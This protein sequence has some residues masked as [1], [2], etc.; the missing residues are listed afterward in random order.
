MGEVP[1]PML[2]VDHTRQADS[3]LIS[4]VGEMDVGN[5]DEARK[6][7]LS[8][9]NSSDVDVIVDMSE[10]EFIDSVGVSMLLEVQRISRADSN[11]LCFRGAHAEVEHILQL[12]RV[13]QQL[14][15][16]D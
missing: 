11:R 3:H 8:A 14:N 9:L 5:V 1:Q 4:L 7:V 15:F 12:T 2:R 16:T 13:D 10:L 6:A